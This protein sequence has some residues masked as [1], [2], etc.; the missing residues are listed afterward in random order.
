MPEPNK[1]LT[2]LSAD[3]V[4]TAAL[5]GL[6]TL[7]GGIT[8]TEISSLTGGNLAVDPSGNLSVESGTFLRRTDIP[9]TAI[10]DTETAV[11]AQFHVPSGQ[12][13]SIYAVGVQTAGQTAPA[14]LTVD[15]HDL[16][17]ATNIH[18]ANTLHAEG[19]PL[20]SKAGAIDVRIRVSNSTGA[21]VD[22]SG[23]VL[24]EVG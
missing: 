17:N 3:Q 20:A 9:L 22:A 21:S 12:T 18:S 6:A 19:S 16:T 7:N 5:V 8:D 1:T 11:G 13:L 10:S 2:N 15:V 4:E 23:Y 14:G 24:Y